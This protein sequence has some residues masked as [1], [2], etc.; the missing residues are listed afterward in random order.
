MLLCV[1]V[2]FKF[3][4]TIYLCHFTNIFLHRTDP[5]PCMNCQNQWYCSEKCRAKDLHHHEPECR[6]Q[7]HSKILNSFGTNALK[8]KISEFFLSNDD[9]ID[10]SRL[11]FRVIKSTKPIKQQV[12][13]DDATN[14]YLFPSESF[15]IDN[16]KR[17][18]EWD[19]INCPIELSEKLVE[20]EHADLINDYLEGYDDLDEDERKG[21]DEQLGLDIPS[22]ELFMELA[23]ENEVKTVLNNTVN[24]VVDSL[25]PTNDS[26]DSSA[27]DPPSFKSSQDNQDVGNT[28]LSASGNTNEGFYSYFLSQIKK[29]DVWEKMLLL[30]KDNR[31]QYLSNCFET[32]KIDSEKAAILRESAAEAFDEEED[33]GQH[34]EGLESLA[35]SLKFYFRI[36]RI[37]TLFGERLQLERKPLDGKFGFWVIQLREILDNDQVKEHYGDFEWEEIVKAFYVVCSLH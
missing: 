3:S 16:Q 18:V 1:N 31:A 6:A 12:N 14:D 20:M 24:T 5:L 28:S 13:D 7:L 15:T 29:K 19:D 37:D 17:T 35:E 25:S 2:I 9:I 34:I 8:G 27:D 22:D 32:F 30:S 33:E 11:F 10:F 36:F 23:L 21:Y 4:I 26:F